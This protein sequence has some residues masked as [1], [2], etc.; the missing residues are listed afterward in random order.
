MSKPNNIVRRAAEFARAAHQGQRRKY[1]GEPYFNHVQAVA[2]IVRAWGGDNTEVAAA[3]LH[4]V[5]EDTDCTYSTLARV[6]GNEVADIVRELTDVYTPHAYPS[7]NRKA[8]KAMETE[9]LSKVS[10]SAKLVKRADIQHNTADIE[11][12]ARHVPAAARFAPVYLA[13]M[14]AL[15]VALGE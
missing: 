7:Y 2:A 15:W 10:K 11:K 1:S 6:F 5:L 13:E 3:L 9:R 8:R 12:Y 4:D 14:Q